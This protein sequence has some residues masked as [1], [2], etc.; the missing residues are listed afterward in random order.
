MPEPNI[1]RRIA[2]GC[3]PRR[4]REEKDGMPEFGIRKSAEIPP[5][6]PA[7]ADDRRQAGDERVN[8]L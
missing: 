1:P 8:K 7:R 6:R 4:F 3:A 2:S 5:R